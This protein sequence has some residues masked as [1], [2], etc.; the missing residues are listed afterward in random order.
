MHPE[1]QAE[2]GSV[3]GDYIETACAAPG[4]ARPA[5]PV[6]CEVDRRR[7]GQWIAELSEEFDALDLRPSMQS[8]EPNTGGSGTLSSERSPAR[9]DVIALR[10][11]VSRGDEPDPMHDGVL[12][13]LVYWTDGIREARGLASATVA[14]TVTSERK[15]LAVHLPWIL[16][17]DAAGLFFDHLRVL[18]GRLRAANDGPRPRVLRCRRIVDG[19]ECGGTIDVAE[20]TARCR[21]C[22][23]TV[24]GLALLRAEVPA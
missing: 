16:E 1:P 23:H 7:A 11:R 12:P 5:A 6:I 15:L 13:V 21:A 18:Y 3:N 17:Q 10:D 9:L 4:C 20:G 8:R 24:S 2:G 19:V 22:G 14:R